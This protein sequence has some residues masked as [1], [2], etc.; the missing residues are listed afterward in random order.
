[1][2]NVSPVLALLKLLVDT[3]CLYIYIYIVLYLVWFRDI[4]FHGVNFFL[5]FILDFY[6]NFQV[7]RP[8]YFPSHF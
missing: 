2:A 8:S 3:I 6:P 7:K 5:F 1:M 4:K